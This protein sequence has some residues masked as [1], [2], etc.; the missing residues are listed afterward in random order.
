MSYPFPK[1]QL[2]PVQFIQNG[3]IKLECTSFYVENIGE[4]PVAFLGR[5]LA[6]GD[7]FT[8]PFTGVIYMQNESIKFLGAEDQTKDLYILQTTSQTCN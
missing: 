2:Y 6:T 5:T 8:V 3:N 1:G 7:S 4:S